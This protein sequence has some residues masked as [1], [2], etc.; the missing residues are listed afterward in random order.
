MTFTP[1]AD[2]SYDV[3][4]AD[5][6]GRRR[7]G[8]VRGAAERRRAR[9]DGAAAGPERHD[10]RE[11]RR[12]RRPATSA[13]RT[14]RPII[15]AERLG[16]VARRR[17]CWPA[18]SATPYQAAR[19]RAESH[20]H[21]T[22]M[23]L[24]LAAAPPLLSVP[25][26]F[27]YERPRFLA[28][29]RRTPIVR[30]LETGIAVAAAGDRRRGA[31][32]RHHRQPARPRAARRRRRAQAHRAGARPGRRQPG[33]SRLDWLEP[34]SP[35]SLRLALRDGNYHAIHYVGH[36]DFTS[37]GNG[38]IYL[39]DPDDG[40][41]GGGRRDAVR[42]PAVGPEPAA[43]GRA[44][45]VRGRPHDAHRSVRGRRHDARPARRAGRRGDA[46]RDQ[47]PR[48]DRLRRGAVHQ[49]DRAP[50]PDR[51]LG[52]RGPQGDLQRRRQGRVGDAGAVRPRPRRRAVP[53]RR[54][55]HA[56][57]ADRPDEARPAAAG[58]T[59]ADRA[60]RL[61]A[62]P[63]DRR[64][65]PSSPSRSSPLVRVAD[66]AGRDLDVEPTTTTSTSPPPVVAALGFPQSASAT[67]ARWW[68]PCNGCSA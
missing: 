64:R 27:L 1:R 24:S 13:A 21:G 29:Q 12:T 61:A 8:R 31:D 15:D 46:V 59:A 40:D 19:A 47:R 53:L 50:R 3:R 49:P 10:A 34:A 62:A 16:G 65:S 68:S 54:G 56:G 44:E 63:R 18:T 25:W 35:R 23:T 51:R 9:A 60:P 2:D 41:V 33:R 6:A 37:D 66:V 20:G 11:P 28:S 55:R 38:V 39:E 4:A 48:R 32:P 58:R 67:T 43:A 26:E 52:G 36:S 22:R 5:A 14:Q 7:L 42:Q 57:S 17:R 45:L 30:L